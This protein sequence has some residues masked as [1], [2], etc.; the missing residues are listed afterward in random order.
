M[1]FVPPPVCANPPPAPAS[2]L[3]PSPY[4]ICCLPSSCSSANL[5]VRAAESGPTGSHPQVLHWRGNVWLQG[6]REDREETFSSPLARYG[7]GFGDESLSTQS[8]SS[9]GATGGVARVSRSSSRRAT[10]SLREDYGT[11]SSSSSEREELRGKSSSFS[12]PSS[13]LYSDLP[14]ASD[15]LGASDLDAYRRTSRGE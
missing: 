11:A 3:F 6:R 1:C 2:V 5:P 13:M 4:C 10:S 12:E 15:L 7:G 9:Q 8:W 14:G